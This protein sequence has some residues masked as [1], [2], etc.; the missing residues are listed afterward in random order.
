MT[1]AQE[2][3]ILATVTEMHRVLSMLDHQNVGRW[4]PDKEHERRARNIIQR[5]ASDAFN[6]K[7]AII[8]MIHFN[9]SKKQ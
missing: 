9:K 3:H 1:P 2:K 8:G 7:E 4:N 5:T 6:L